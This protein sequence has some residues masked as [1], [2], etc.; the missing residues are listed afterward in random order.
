MCL[1][2]RGGTSDDSAL[3]SLGMSGIK[4]LVGPAAACGAN[5]GNKYSSIGD[6]IIGGIVIAD[7]LLEPSDN[8]HLQ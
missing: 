2:G 4:A 1:L 8:S 3:A 7:F 5:G 6:Q